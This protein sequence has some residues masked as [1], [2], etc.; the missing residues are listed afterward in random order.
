MLCAIIIT[1]LLTIMRILHTGK[2]LFDLYIKKN[3]LY[4]DGI[5][6]TPSVSITFDG[7]TLKTVRIYK[8][9]FI[10][11]YFVSTNSGLINPCGIKLD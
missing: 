5:K 8:Y 4:I 11:K 1:T 10:N 3:F 9:L 6:T 2:L 7:I